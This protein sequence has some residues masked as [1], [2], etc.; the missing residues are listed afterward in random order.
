[1]PPTLTPGDSSA[2]E[3][4][5]EGF[6][7]NN[8]ATS[9][10][11]ADNSDTETKTPE[12][13]QGESISDDSRP[14]VTNVTAGAIDQ[15]QQIP[16][17]NPETVSEA[18]NQDDKEGRIPEA[19]RNSEAD[20]AIPDNA[21]SLD[22]G[23]SSHRDRE[24]SGSRTGAL[25]ESDNDEAA[26]TSLVGSI[27]T[28][29]D[30]TVASTTASTESEQQDRGNRATT[31]CTSTGPNPDEME[32]NS[33]ATPALTFSDYSADGNSEPVTPQSTGFDG[34]NG[35]PVVAGSDDDDAA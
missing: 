23:S 15:V 22:Q 32:H 16:R 26:P 8:L 28:S 25:T 29:G 7:E 21:G 2:A 18:E 19:T 17:E 14:T 12:Q 5:Q 1:M 9:T 11:I 34:W 31:T 3:S 4:A 6:Q 27:P 24:N 30:N 35:S 20:Q 13:S 33:P 10:P